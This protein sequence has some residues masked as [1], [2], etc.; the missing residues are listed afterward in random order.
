MRE[1]LA[2]NICRCGTHLRI[3]RAVKRAGSRV[4]VSEAHDP[5]QRRRRHRHLATGAPRVGG[6]SGGVRLSAVGH[7][8]RPASARPPCGPA[9]GGAAAKS[10]AADEVDAF[11]AIGARRRGH[12]LHRQG[13]SRHRRAHGPGADRRRGAGRADR[14]DRAS[15]RATPRC[16]PDQGATYGSLSLQN[17]GTQIRQ[18]AGDARDSCACAPRERLGVPRRGSLV[19]R[20]G[21]VSRARGRPRRVSYGELVGGRRLRPAGGH[22]RPDQE[23]R[24]ASGGRHV[25][26]R[27]ST[28][29]SK[30][31]G[32]F[33][34][35]HDFRVPGMLHG[36]VVRPPALGARWPAV[37][38]ASV[39]AIPGVVQGGAPG[40]L[41]RRRRGERV[42]TPS[43]PRRRWRRTWSDWQGLPEQTQA[44]GARPRARA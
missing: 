41:R 6:A 20:D 28:S 33:D 2:N 22:G 34:Y 4:D 42:G 26:R 44:L 18:A 23:P 11:L 15:S 36:R 5:G 14:A 27:A 13:G 12:A 40:R 9:S 37:D 24:R 30:V 32:R 39:A 3:L 25:G 19:T 17:G 16:T 29:R 10:V 31:T 35:V 1:A 7:A 43:A 8:Q 38:E 21:T